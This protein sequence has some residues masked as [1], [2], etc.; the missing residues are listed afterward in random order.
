[1]DLIL[2]KTAFPNT[3]VTFELTCYGE[4]GILIHILHRAEEIYM[5][6]PGPQAYTFRL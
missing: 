1:V 4:M 2:L 5:M 3:C 6:T